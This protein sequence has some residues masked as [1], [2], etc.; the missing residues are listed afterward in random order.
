[1]PVV[2]IILTNAYRFVKQHPRLCYTLGLWK[3]VPYTD[4][5][6]TEK[7]RVQMK[8]NKIK[9]APGMFVYVVHVVFLTIFCTLC[10]HVQVT[11]RI[12]ASA[13]P[14]LYWFTA[15]HFFKVPA[16]LEDEEKERQKG[17]NDRNAIRFASFLCKLSNNK[18]ENA[19]V[20]GVDSLENLQSR[21]KVFILTDIAPNQEAKLIQY[22]FLAYVVLGTALFSNFLPWT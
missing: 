1:M 13:S 2:C 16:S 17:S 7:L 9:F 10:I 5:K 18:R 20:E 14:V 4:S 11:T 21:W 8:E 22:Y 15:Y 6:V 3:V 12:V 19:L